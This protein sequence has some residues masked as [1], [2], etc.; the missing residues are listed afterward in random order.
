MEYACAYWVLGAETSSC[1]DSDDMISFLLLSLSAEDIMIEEEVQRV[2]LR[3]RCLVMS[4]CI[5]LAEIAVSAA[6][7]M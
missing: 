7:E 2:L 1:S 6:A 3:V 5:M 4:S